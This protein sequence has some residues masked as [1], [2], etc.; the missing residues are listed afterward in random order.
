MY[1]EYV[2]KL[3]SERAKEFRES[4]WPQYEFDVWTDYLWRNNADLE[5]D[6]N[7]NQI[8]SVHKDILTELRYFD[9][10]LAN[11]DFTDNSNEEMREQSHVLERLRH[12]P[13]YENY[14][15]V[16]DTEHH[17]SGMM[18][19][20]Y[21]RVHPLQ[22]SPTILASGGGGTWGYHYERERGKLTNR[23]RARLQSFPD[24]FLFEGTNAEVRKQIG[25]AVPPLGAKR[26]G[27]EILSVL[28]EI[29][30]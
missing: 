20:T 15:M 5:T 10:S 26:I 3:D 18:S 28:N 14:R 6:H 12:I 1:E 16:E 21:R 25:N 24:D 9:E 7:T 4:I 29:V 27:E 11:K 13:P 17:V 30:E 22:P 8:S 23:E 2:S 19:N